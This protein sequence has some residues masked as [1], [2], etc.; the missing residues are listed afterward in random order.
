MKAIVLAVG[1]ILAVRNTGINRLY[2]ARSLT[3]LFAIECRPFYDNV[4]PFNLI[5]ENYVL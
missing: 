4:K 1:A 2:R 5:G 3:L